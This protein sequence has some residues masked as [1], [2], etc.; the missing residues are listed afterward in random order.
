MIH[1]YDGSAC[2]VNICQIFYRDE[3]RPYLDAAFSP[4]DNSGHDDETLEFGV[5]QRL[6]GGASF[7]G[8]DYF[9]ALSWRF[10]EKTG[11]T[12]QDLIEAV[13][14]NPRVDLFYMNPFPHNEAIHQSLWLQGET[15]HPG[16]LEVCTA[17]FEAAELEPTDIYR[18][19]PSSGFSVC[20]YFVARPAFWKAYIPFVERCLEKAEAGMPVDLCKRMHSAEGDWKGIHKG[21]TYVPFIIERLLPAFLK[22]PDGRTL[23]VHK[24]ALPAKEAK[25]NDDLRELREMKD[26]AILAHSAR[27]LDLWREKREAYCHIYF[28][29]AW[30]ECNLKLLNDAPVVW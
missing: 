22:S 3:Q 23:R 27:I 17:F 9:G 29:K 19:I 1:T 20:N 30:C 14:S 15:A 25:L 26:V 21:A 24:V 18:L 4:L 10:T 8:A 28:S 6:Y 11:L 13:R 7:E 12:G 2:S 5:F 16:F